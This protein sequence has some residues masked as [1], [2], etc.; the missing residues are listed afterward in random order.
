M[1]ILLL[2]VFGIGAVLW[3]TGTHGGG[4]QGNAW[5]LRGGASSQN[6]AVKDQS[7]KKPTKKKGKKRKKPKKNLPEASVASG[8]ISSEKSAERS[9]QKSRSGITAAKKDFKTNSQ[10]GSKKKTPDAGSG[11]SSSVPD[12]SKYA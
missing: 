8:K 11:R 3:L 12:S 2:I 7:N 4:G 6:P 1:K 9:P 5:H 10:A